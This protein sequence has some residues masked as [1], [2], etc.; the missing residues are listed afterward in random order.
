MDILAVESS[1][2]DT[3]AAI[4]RNGREI[5]NFKASSQID[6]HKI[7]GG[8]VPEVA[9]RNHIESIS[10]DESNNWSER[11]WP[12]ALIRCICFKN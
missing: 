11:C 2:D 1:C 10:A 6:K 9:S 8:V 5:V 4:V 12:L 7:F 3:A